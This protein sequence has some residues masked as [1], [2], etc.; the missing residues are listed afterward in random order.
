MSGQSNQVKEVN[1]VRG[2][3]QRANAQLDSDV[4]AEACQRAD[5]DT[6]FRDSATGLAEG[7]QRTHLAFAEATVAE[8]LVQ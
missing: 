2:L 4:A 7:H 8:F 5:A 6:E 1:Q 3:R